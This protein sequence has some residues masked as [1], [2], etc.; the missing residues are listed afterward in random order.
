MEARQLGRAAAWHLVRLAELKPEDES[1][2][3][4][5]VAA[6]EMAADWENVEASASRAIAADSRDVTSRI[7]RTWSL[8]HL[9]PPGGGR[10]RFR[11]ALDQDADPPDPTRPLRGGGQ[12]G[13]YGRCESDLEPVVNDDETRSDRWN[14]LSAG[15][16]AR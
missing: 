8:V 2:P 16:L 1:I 14:G 3:P 13:G 7:R 12:L 6:H 11:E 15:H 4:R 10:R 9:G 5:L